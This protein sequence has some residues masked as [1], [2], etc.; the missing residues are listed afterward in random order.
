MAKLKDNKTKELESKILK[1]ERELNF[2]R[3]EA[4]K[5]HQILKQKTTRQTW[6]N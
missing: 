6:Q 3:A 1:L 4:L 5:L 2:W